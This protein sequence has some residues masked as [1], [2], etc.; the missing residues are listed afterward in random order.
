MKFCKLNYG[1][2]NLTENSNC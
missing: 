1:E 2:N